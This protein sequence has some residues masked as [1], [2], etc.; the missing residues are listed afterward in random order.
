MKSVNSNIEKIKKQ[1]SDG[2]MYDAMALML[3]CASAVSEYTKTLVYPGIKEAVETV[4][5]DYERMLLFFSD[6][7]RDPERKSIYNRY[8]QNLLKIARKME[9]MYLINTYS[10]YSAAYKRTVNFNPSVISEKLAAFSENIKVLTEE[11]EEKYGDLKDAYKQK[12]DYDKLLFSYLLVSPQWG[13]YEAHSFLELIVSGNAD[14]V[15]ASLMTSA[16]M[17]SCMGIYDFQKLRCLALVYQ[18]A[19]DVNVKERALVGVALSLKGALMQSEKDLQKGLINKLCEETPE[20]IAEFAEL[21]KQ[22]LCSLDT[23]KKTE[24]FQKD[25]DNLI[26][27]GIPTEKLMKDDWDSSDMEEG[28]SFE[29]EEKMELADKYFNKMREMEQSGIDIYF[30]GFSKMKN[31]AFF[32]T[33][34]NWFV[35]YYYEN[36]SLHSS[37]NLLDEQTMAMINKLLTSRVHICD[38]DKYSMAYAIGMTM[39]HAPELNQMLTKMEE[40]DKFSSVD[41]IDT[42]IEPSIVRRQY[43]QSLYRFAKLCTM[44]SYLDDPFDEKNKSFTFF[45]CRREFD[46]ESFEKVKLAIC[47]YLTKQKDYARLGEILYACRQNNQVDYMMMKA[48]FE[49]HHEH[50]YASALHCIT[51]VL[52]KAPNNIP[53]LKLMG[54][55]YY[56]MENYDEAANVY[57]RLIEIGKNKDAY[58]VKLACCLLESGEL[59]EGIQLLF[60]QEYHHPDQKDILRALA[61]GLLQRGQLDKALDYYARLVRVTADEK[62]EGRADDLYHIGLVCFCSHDIK[63]AIVYFTQFL[64][65]AQIEDLAEKLRQDETFMAKFDLS[66]VDIQLMEDSVK[67]SYNNKHSE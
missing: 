41:Q 25:M 53:A 45:L 49:F 29:E 31:F 21:Q 61:W 57:E 12:A 19:E 18:Q 7:M 8:S 50:D 3:S 34:S 36:P 32:H 67:L 51:S 9:L 14:T 54:R 23:Q 38:S 1:L 64:Q 56:L 63:Q 26:K 35:P 37:Q 42:K 60:E 30:D 33:F 15:T 44:N 6:G 59:N 22:L 52:L 27:A 40:S 28:S 62:G 16:I 66:I 17:I 20:A 10:V 5:E 11:G 47:R 43:L 46:T 4:K 2:K 39:K 24:D 55:C 65:I 13:E 48:L 58:K